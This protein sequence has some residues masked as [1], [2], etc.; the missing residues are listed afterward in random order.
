M[1]SVINRYTTKDENFGFFKVI[2]THHIGHIEFGS[3]AFDFNIPSTLFDD[4]RPRLPGASEL[5]A[6][7]AADES[8]QKAA[9][10]PPQVVVFGHEPPAEP[11]QAA[12]EPVEVET[13]EFLTDMSRFFD[14]FQER[15][16]A[17][18]SFTVL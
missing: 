5:K 8:A 11:I 18:D 17:L 6:A 2:S 14:L 9:A 4:L 10:N 15:R 1:P 7:K 12:A 13:R 3:F 16:L